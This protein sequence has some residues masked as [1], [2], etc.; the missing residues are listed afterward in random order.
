MGA[1][2]PAVIGLSG[3]SVVMAYLSVKVPETL[4]VLSVLFLSIS[5][6]TMLVVLE[7]VM[8]ESAITL[9]A[10]E[11]AATIW[12]LRVILAFVFLD[13]LYQVFIIFSGREPEDQVITMGDDMRFQ[14]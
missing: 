12:V 13:L 1:E 6:L 8:D 9:L 11:Y 2:L 3:L 7:I 5:I 14:G 4:K 10:T